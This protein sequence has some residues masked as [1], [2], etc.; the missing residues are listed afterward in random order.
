MNSEMQSSS[1]PNP[2]PEDSEVYWE[3]YVDAEKAAEFLGVDLVTVHCWAEEGRIPAQPMNDRDRQGWRFLVSELEAWL[4]HAIKVA[5]PFG[6]SDHGCNSQPV[7]E[8]RWTTKAPC[9]E[10]NELLRA[11]YAAVGRTH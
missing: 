9:P 10:E 4:D 7:T 3:Y 2:A 11:R 1:N 6:A 5:Q 8:R